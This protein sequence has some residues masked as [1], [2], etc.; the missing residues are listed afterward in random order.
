M[1]SVKSDSDF[2][3]PT[4]NEAILSHPISHLKRLNRIWLP[5]E[6]AIRNFLYIPLRMCSPTYTISYI[7]FVNRVHNESGVDTAQ[8]KTLPIDLIEVVLEPVDGMAP[9]S[10][11]LD[12]TYA[13]HGSNWPRVDY[14]TIERFFSFT[15]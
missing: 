4:L 8:S 5:S 7:D 2:E 12:R 13:T 3:P 15:L 1:L 10:V 6:I 14:R 11:M 9:E